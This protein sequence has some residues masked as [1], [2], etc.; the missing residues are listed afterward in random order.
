ML[1]KSIEC[2]DG[3]LT[4]PAELAMKMS[5]WAGFKSNN[6]GILHSCSLLVKVACL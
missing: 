5:I 2:L 3:S 4:K 1:V 6:I